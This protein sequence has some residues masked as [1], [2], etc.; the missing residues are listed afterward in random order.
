MASNRE[1]TL[2]I[3]AEQWKNFSKFLTNPSFK[4][5]IKATPAQEEFINSFMIVNN[6]F[7]KDFE[8]WITLFKMNLSMTLAL[9]VPTSVSAL[10]S[11]SLE[12]KCN[13][14]VEKLPAVVNAFKVNHIITINCKNAS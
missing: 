2:K 10:D 6:T 11:Y 1:S 4:D 7:N 5:L 3:T 8:E 13:F 12:E 14:I 9:D